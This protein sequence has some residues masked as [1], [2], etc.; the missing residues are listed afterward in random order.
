[1]KKIALI[2]MFVSLSALM[3]LAQNENAISVPMIGSEAPAFKAESTNG[4]INF[5]RDFGKS[6]KIIFSHPRDFTPVCSSE[7]LELSYLQP[8]FDKLGVK[9]I[10]VSTDNLSQHNDWKA[11]LETINYGGRAP[12][13]INFPIV[14]DADYS[15]AR[16]YGMIQPASSD[17][18]DVRGVF[19]I[20]PDNIVQAIMFYP[21][22]VGRNMDEIKRT[23]I[24]LQ[25]SQDNVVIPAN[26]KPGG[27]VM[28]SYLTEEQKTTQM[29]ENSN[30]I[31]EVVWYMVFRKMP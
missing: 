28:L 31:Y 20:N 10:V 29:D 21:M 30:D 27:D 24:A 1:M 17:K 15:I 12:K 25:T 4:T 2:I 16:E 5:P 18:K 3:A 6:W 13:K 22:N 11:S 23:V 26:W 7:L 9:L 19:I 8:D 14:S